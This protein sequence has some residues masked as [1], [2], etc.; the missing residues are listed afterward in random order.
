MYMYTKE[1]MAI[2][3]AMYM[4]TYEYSK[5]QTAIKFDLM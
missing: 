5:G 1:Q 3:F 4:F 2:K